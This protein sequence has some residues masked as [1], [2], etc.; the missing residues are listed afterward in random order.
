MDSDGEDVAQGFRPAPEEI[1]FRL[2]NSGTER[3][4]CPANGNAPEVEE[5]PGGV[6]W[7]VRINHSQHY[8]YRLELVGTSK[9]DFPYWLNSVTFM[10]KNGKECKIRQV[11]NEYIVQFNREDVGGYTAIR[12]DDDQNCPLKMTWYTPDDSRG[13]KINAIL[14][15]SH[16]NCP[17]KK[18]HLGTAGDTAKRQKTDN[19]SGGRQVASLCVGNPGGHDDPIPIDTRRFLPEENLIVDGRI[20][21]NTLITEHL[22]CYSDE[23]L[24]TILSP[25]HA[26]MLPLLRTLE[27]YVYTWKD[28]TPDAGPMAQRIFELFG[29]DIEGIVTY[30]DGGIPTSLEEIRSKGLPD[31]KLVVKQNALKSVQFKALQELA[32]T[33]DTIQ[34]R[35]AGIVSTQKAH[36]TRIDQ[37]EWQMPATLNALLRP[38]SY[39]CDIEDGPRDIEACINYNLVRE[40]SH[41]NKFHNWVKTRLDSKVYVLSADKTEI[42]TFLRAS[43]SVVAYHFCRGDDP[44]KKNPVPAIRSIAHQL[45][46]AF[47]EYKRKLQKDFP[48]LRQRL[49]E[50][51]L[52][53]GS[54]EKKTV[55]ALF[56]LL[57]KEPL[58]TLRRP[59]ERKVILIDAVDECEEHGKNDFL[60]CIRD[61]FINLPSWLCF[62]L[63]T[64]PEVN[65]MKTLKEFPSGVVVVGGGGAGDQQVSLSGMHSGDSASMGSS[66]WGSASTGSNNGGRIQV[67]TGACH[68]TV[69]GM[70]PSDSAGES[71]LGGDVDTSSNAF[72][73]SGDGGGSSIGG[74]VGE[75]ILNA[76]NTGLIAWGSTVKR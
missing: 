45:T 44:D 38:L 7:A 64:R 70:T 43:D 22:R 14:T 11:G 30:A 8:K 68:Q 61:Y 72:G 20:D 46:D 12:R 31:G 47:P 26:N 51:N 24:K 58:S 4:W 41:L 5:Q 74:D 65:I 59:Y 28:G 15:K 76:I 50:L 42:A 71:S 37:L 33:V 49:F 23:R 27:Q 66:M 73:S 16:N 32:D 63:T 18:R 57:L 35:L 52:A 10:G 6:G 1:H 29:K 19:V 13:T 62:L 55:K 34:D 2:D 25:L 9:G 54:L 69:A 3:G 53:P 60:R 75:H 48:I 21:C 36:A 17:P 56:D 39:D 67:L 40:L